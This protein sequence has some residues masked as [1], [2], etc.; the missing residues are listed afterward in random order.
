MSMRAAIAGSGLVAL[1]FVAGVAQQNNLPQSAKGTFATDSSDAQS[2][3]TIAHQQQKPTAP[4][5]KHV[6]TNEDMPSHPAPAP[7]PEAKPRIQLK[8][9]QLE[10]ISDAKKPSDDGEDLL[11]AIRDEKDTIA[12]MQAALDLMEAKVETWKGDDCRKYY[13]ESG[14]YNDS[15]PEVTKLVSDRDRAK[16][17]LEKEQAALAEMQEKARKAGFTSKQYD[18]D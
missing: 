14:V 7:A 12:E 5:P 3:G 10:T 1:L 18:P 13:S 2:L 4:A 8:K 17:S 6:I 9:T 11:T 16:K 15:C